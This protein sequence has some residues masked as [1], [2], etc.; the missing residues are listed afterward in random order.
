[1]LHFHNVLVFGLQLEILAQ[2][3]F[4]KLRFRKKLISIPISNYQVQPKQNQQKVV[5]ES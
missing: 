1:M 5:L 2:V 3:N 4:S